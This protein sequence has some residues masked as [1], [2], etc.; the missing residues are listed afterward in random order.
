MEG[1]WGGESTGLGDKRYRCPYDSDGF[2]FDRTVKGL[3]V[4]GGINFFVNGRMYV[5]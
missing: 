2:I 5:G 4:G 1:F 3:V